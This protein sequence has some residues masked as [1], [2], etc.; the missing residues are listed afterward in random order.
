MNE[1]KEADFK[2]EH[3]LLF[4]VAEWGFNIDP[5]HEFMRFRIG[6]CEG[7]WSG[8][9]QSYEILAVKNTQ[10]HNGHFNDVLQWF[11][12]SCIRDKKHFIIKEVWNKNLKNHLILK[13][14]FTK[15]G[16][17]DLIKYFN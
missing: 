3:N 7:L 6:T 1:L 16:K 12:H 8:T 10:K 9:D 5:D 14:G 17:S 13:R 11:E 4:E 15:L 2:T